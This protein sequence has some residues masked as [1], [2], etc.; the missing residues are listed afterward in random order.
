MSAEKQAE[1]TV[2]TP[3]FRCEY[4]CKCFRLLPGDAA[5]TERAV[6][7]EASEPALGESPVLGMPVQIVPVFPPVF[8][9]YSDERTKKEGIRTEGGHDVHIRHTSRL[10]K[11]GIDDDD[12]FVRAFGELTTYALGIRHL[13]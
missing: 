8:D 4:F 1:I 3:F 2:H 7:I 10:R 12:H 5:H 11:A 6:D 9:D 13:M